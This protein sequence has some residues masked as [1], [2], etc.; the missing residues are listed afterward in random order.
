MNPSSTKDP[1]ARIPVKRITREK[2]DRVRRQQRWALNVVADEAIDALIAKLK[3][4]GRRSG[5]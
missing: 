4:N 3:R 5:G 2:F 1:F